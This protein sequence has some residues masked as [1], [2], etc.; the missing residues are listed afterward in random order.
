M[1]STITPDVFDDVYAI[2]EP[3]WYQNPWILCGVGGV[4]LLL[5]FLGMFAIYRRRR[6]DIVTISEPERIVQAIFA[7]PRQSL[8]ER[9]Y[10][11]ELTRL[12]KAYISFHKGWQSSALTDEEFVAQ[13]RTNDLPQQVIE[14]INILYEHAAVIKYAHESIDQRQEDYERSLMC[15]NILSSL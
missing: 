14:A 8:S 15:I 3:Q 5:V 7:L 10:Y 12:T 9:D 4:L 6:F 11:G 2:W 13:C 1:N